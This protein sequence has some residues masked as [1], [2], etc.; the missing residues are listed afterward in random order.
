MSFEEAIEKGCTFLEKG[1]AIERGI[2]NSSV[3]EEKKITKCV[4]LW[5]EGVECI[6]GA[7]KT[8]TE[9]TEGQSRTELKAIVKQYL[10]KVEKYQRIIQQQNHKKIDSQGS[11]WEYIFGNRG[12]HRN[13]YN[14]E[15]PKALTNSSSQA[16]N[17]SRGNN[18]SS[19]D[20]SNSSIE[21]NI[22]SN[23]NSN[24]KSIKAEEERL[25]A[26]MKKRLATR[27]A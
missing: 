22:S 18:G 16:N 20:A 3:F 12:K 1:N 26:Q 13:D 17:N 5:K 25:I 7:L 24:S 4:E 9:K 21:T 23:V 19:T 8:Q 11:L 15:Q 27:R 14:N 6:L 2:K 10:D